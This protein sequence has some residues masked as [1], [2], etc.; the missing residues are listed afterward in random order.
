LLGLCLVLHMIIK[1]KIGRA[2]LDSFSDQDIDSLF[3]ECSKETL[4]ELKK[5]L[6]TADTIPSILT[7]S[8]N[9]WYLIGARVVLNNKTDF[10]SIVVYPSLKCLRLW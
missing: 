7:F 8:K 3:V 6:K 2:I 9:K 4:N 10:G 1:N 5:T